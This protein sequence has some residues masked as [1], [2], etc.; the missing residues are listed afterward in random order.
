ALGNSGVIIALSEILL[1]KYVS[2]GTRQSAALAIAKVCWNASSQVKALTSGAVMPLIRM[3]LDS[4]ERHWFCGAEALMSLSTSELVWMGLDSRERHWCCDAEALIS[5][6]MSEANRKVIG[7]AGALPA[8][9]EKLSIHGRVEA[10]V[11][12]L[13]TLCN[14]VAVESNA[15]VAVDCG[16]LVRVIAMSQSSSPLLLQYLLIVM[17]ILSDQERLKRNFVQAGLV[18]C[19]LRL[20]DHFAGDGPDG[21]MPQ[22]PSIRGN[23]SMMLCTVA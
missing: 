7:G 2:E 1:S 8:L 13:A 10:Q 17:R 12:L 21:S 11:R 22:A 3:V 6:S 23:L 15:D 14:L 16:L 5:P 4:R 18:E 20:L 9:I 19:L